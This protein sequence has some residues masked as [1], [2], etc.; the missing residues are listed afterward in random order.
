MDVMKV[1]LFL[2]MDAPV[3]MDLKPGTDAVF[4]LADLIG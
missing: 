1:P 4:H 2:S 3:R